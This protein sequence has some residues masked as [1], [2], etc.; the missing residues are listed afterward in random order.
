MTQTQTGSTR[1]EPVL[2]KMTVSLKLIQTYDEP[3]KARD[4]PITIV[5]GGVAIKIG[6]S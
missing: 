2:Y 6:K 1:Q 5:H 3:E 4:Q